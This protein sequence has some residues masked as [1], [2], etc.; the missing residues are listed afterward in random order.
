MKKALC[1]AAAIA[2]AGPAVAQEAI[3][4]QFEGSYD[5]ATFAVENAIIDRGLVIDYVSHVGD[6]LARTGPDL[7]SD[8]EI[9][10]QAQIF[11]F[12]SASASRRAMEADWLNIVHCPYGI[13]VAQVDGEVIVGHR[14]YPDGPMQE[15][16]AVLDAIILEARGS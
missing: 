15:V 5:D 7:G 8:V 2:V 9:F 13:F 3:T 16:E 10:E 14:A 6:M 12:C 4:Y 1:L 11:I